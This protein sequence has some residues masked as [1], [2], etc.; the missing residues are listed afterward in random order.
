M[1][2]LLCDGP[3]EGGRDERK[4]I[5]VLNSSEVRVN[6]VHFNAC[7]VIQLWLGNHDI[8]YQ[9]QSSES[10]IYLRVGH[11][12]PKTLYYTNK[13]IVMLKCTN[14]HNVQYVIFRVITFD[15]SRIILGVA[16]KKVFFLF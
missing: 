15:M 10:F 7:T 4:S 1:T 9:I 13:Q 16:E 3:K 11:Y 8:S 2:V 14:R 12:C 5:E 6:T